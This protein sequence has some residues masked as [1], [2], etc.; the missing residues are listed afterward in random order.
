M[1]ESKE[2][3]AGTR[4][5]LALSYVTQKND[6]AVKTRDTKCTLLK[7]AHSH[8]KSE[9]SSYVPGNFSWQHIVT[10]SSHLKI[11]LIDDSLKITKKCHMTVVAK[12]GM[13]GQK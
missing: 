8:Q 12:T 1:Y 7:S 9:N 13:F 6:R 4:G 10:S 5:W 3:E 11:Q 2:L